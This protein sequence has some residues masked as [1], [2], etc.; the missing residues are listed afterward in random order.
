MPLGRRA[1]RMARG[2]RMSSGGRTFRGGRTSRGGRVRIEHMIRSQVAV[3]QPFREIRE[4]ETH[5]DQLQLLV[6][7]SVQTN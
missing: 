6:S 3:Q 5:D 2:G 1:A 4:T 7:F